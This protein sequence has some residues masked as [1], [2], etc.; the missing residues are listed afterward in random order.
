MKRLILSLLIVLA[1]SSVSEAKLFWRLPRAK[2]AL[3]AAF[4]KLCGPNGCKVAT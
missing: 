4:P 2:A 3:K 1:L